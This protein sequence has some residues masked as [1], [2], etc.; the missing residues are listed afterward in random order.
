MSLVRSLEAPLAKTLVIRPGFSFLQPFVNEYVSGCILRFAT[1]N[2]CRMTS[3][4]LLFTSFFLLAFQLSQGQ[5]STFLT[6]QLRYA[7]VKSAKENCASEWKSTLKK[8]QI[9]EKKLTL[10]IRAFKQEGSLE[11]WGKNKE[12]ASFQLLR[13][14]K[15]CA[16]SGTLGPKVQQG[17]GQ[18]PEGVYSIDRFN[19]ASSYYLSLGL[20]YPNNIDKARSAEKAPGGDIFIHGECVTIGCLPMTNEKIEEIYLLAVMAKSAGQST[21]GVH[22]FPFRM[23]KG[24]ME[25]ALKTTEGKKWGAFWKNLQSVYRY[26]EDTK[27]PGTWIKGEGISYK[28][29]V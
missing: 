20:S 27:T 6:E 26:F 23:E 22:V 21:I 4:K 19:P 5:Q 10:F 11:L 9:E 8:H 7:R 3:R 17:D 18:V 28:R 29:K 15:V 2:S 14:Y 24:Q 1:V 12:D 16:K 25:L 13:S